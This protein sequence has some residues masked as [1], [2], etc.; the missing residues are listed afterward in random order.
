MSND[1]ENAATEKAPISSDPTA[2]GS[3]GAGMNLLR[4]ITTAAP[5]DPSPQQKSIES[6]DAPLTSHASETAE[7]EAAIRRG[8]ARAAAKVSGEAATPREEA[9]LRV[10]PAFAALAENVRDYAVFLMDVNGVIVYWGESAR[11]LKWWT[12]EEAED[13][14]LRL[15]YPE[16]GSEDGTAEDHLQQAAESG[17]YVGEGQRVRGDGS[18]FWAHVTLTRLLDEE[19]KLVGFVKLTRDMTARRAVE[20]A[21]ALANEAQTTRERAMAVAQEAKAAQERAEEAEAFA[22]EAIKSA[23]DYIKRELEPALAIRTTSLPTPTEIIAAN[24][25]MRANVREEIRLSTR[26]RESFDRLR[27]AQSKEA[28]AGE[29]SESVAPDP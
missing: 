21:V 1:I 4:E 28:E 13:A 14:H 17:E 3:A 5:E 9:L 23:H 6:S 7:R 27:S 24:L 16:G 20:M 8:H 18:T 10:D 19:G 26:L 25:Q 15:L 2:H 11:L 29:A 12:K 22:T